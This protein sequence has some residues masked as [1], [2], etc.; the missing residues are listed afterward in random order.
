M[1]QNK[2]K[3]V[4]IGGGTYTLLQKKLKAYKQVNFSAV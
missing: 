4:V 1:R 2:Y 3:I